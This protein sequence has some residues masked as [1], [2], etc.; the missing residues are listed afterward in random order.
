[1]YVSSEINKSFKI[2]TTTT[3]KGP[4]SVQGHG[5]GAKY[6]F[7]GNNYKKQRVGA[8]RPKYKNKYFNGESEIIR[9]ENNGNFCP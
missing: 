4:A 6:C 9:K 1:M 8:A 5:K 7:Y 3:T 2:L